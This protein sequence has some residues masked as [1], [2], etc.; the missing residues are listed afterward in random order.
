MKSRT[1]TKTTREANPYVVAVRR[2]R[3]RILSAVVVL[4]L[5]LA[6]GCSSG[7]D[8]VVDT[9]GSANIVGGPS[10]V[11]ATLKLADYGRDMQVISARGYDIA[12]VDLDASEV[13]LV[14]EHATMTALR[15]EGFDVVRSKEVPLELEE[16]AERGLTTNYKAPGDVEALIQDYAAR[17]PELAAA[18]SI[19]KS[20]QGRDIW[21]LRITKNVGAAH[22]PAKPVILF[23][24]AHHAREL[25]S[26]E[27]PFDTI[28][29]LLNGYGTDPKITHWVD[30]NEIWVMPMLNVD[31][32]N[33]VF[34][35]DTMWRKNAKGCPASGTCASHTGVD[36]NRNYPY[37]WASCNGSSSS[38]RADDYHGP[39]AASEPE[40]NAMMKLVADIRPVFDISYHSYS[41][42]VL[43]PY[44]CRGQHVPSQAVVSDFA[45]KMAA[46]LPSDD[47]PGRN[48]RPGTPWE[49]LYSAD[50]GDMDWM[51]HEYQVMAYAIE[52][53]GTR[54]GFQP[55]FSTWRQKTV[56][57]LRGAWQ[58]MLDRVDGPGVRGIVH[59]V[60][61]AQVEVTP[62]SGTTSPT[63]SRAVNP[64]GS[65][66]I[67]T[68]PG[69]YK[70]TVTAPGHS[71][72]T[73]TVTVGDTR[74]DLDI[75]LP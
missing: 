40:T 52:I 19:G 16:P 50:G 59:D 14:V 43:Y 60:A 66:H 22:D 63:E 33:Q 15:N 48:Y 75:R 8:D 34:T 17:F 70:V 20:S 36:I 65:F 41:E 28:D 7:G 13:D 71:A 37:G 5:V 6:S 57:K 24:G 54:Q 31:G 56:T 3:P 49:L 12:G 69:T 1:R 73:Q 47:S 51:Y 64:D 58:L 68:L 44:G 26:V 74:A 39:S 21:V 10:R 55:S 11:V 25:M 67:V 32:S 29:T 9:G 38:T 46:K 72:Y 42:V 27:V 18:K 2:R 4:G 45:Q 35:H 53:N 23:N 62:A 30:A 61:G